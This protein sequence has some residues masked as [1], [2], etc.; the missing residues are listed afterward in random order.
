[1]EGARCGVAHWGPPAELV[2]AVSHLFSGEGT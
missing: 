1:V 2:V